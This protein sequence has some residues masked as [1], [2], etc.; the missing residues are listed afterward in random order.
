MPNKFWQ[1][2]NAADG[3][4]ELLLYGNI[5]GEK[6]WYSDDVTPKQ[7]AEDL[8]ALGAVSNITVR[9]NSGGGDV[10]AAVEIGNLL[11]QHPANVTARIGG[12]CASAATII[13]CH[14]NKVIAANDSTYM[15]HPVSMYC[16]YANAAD[17]QKYLEALATIKE[18]IISLYAKKT[19][20]TKE[21]V[22]AWMDAESWWTG[23]QAKENGFVD[24]LTDEESG[25]TYENRGGVLFVNSV[26]M[27]AEFDKAPEFVR[28]RVK[29][30]VDI[31]PP[32][33]AQDNQPAGQPG[34]QQEVQDMDPKDSI[35]TVDDLRKAYPTLVDQI[36]QAAVATATEAATNA[37]RARIQSIEDM[38]LP[39][40][41]KL[42]AEAK[43]TEP[44]SAAD[45]AEAM[46]KNA[47]TQGATYLAQVQKDAEGS[48]VNNVTN[49]PPADKTEGDAFIAAIK[50]V[51]P[52]N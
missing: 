16:G 38:A 47:K 19:G 32:A 6:S 13:A 29:R 31:T 46:V 49:T 7:F 43:F 17:L 11:E 48:G 22:T 20:R 36:E 44:M 30:V 2:R 24:E 21:E 18:N 51:A 8:A 42:A 10:F 39:G 45:F 9:I 15:V 50:G 23:P 1:F 14:C 27:G 41:E 25:A 40:S 5:A 37:E 33:Q 28:N 4:G 3:S 52:K 34:K 35:K 26:S 12:V